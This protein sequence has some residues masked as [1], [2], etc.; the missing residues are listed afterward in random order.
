VDWVCFAKLDGAVEAT[1]EIGEGCGGDCLLHFG[2]NPYQPAA[3]AAHLFAAGDMP[4]IFA[5]DD[6]QSIAL[7][8]GGEVPDIRNHAAQ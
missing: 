8:H 1:D 3:P 2:R 6:D 7:L 5:A 4:M